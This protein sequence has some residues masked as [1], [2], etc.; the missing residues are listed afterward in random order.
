MDDALGWILDVVESVDPVLRMTIAGVAMLLELSVV[1]GLIVPGDTIVIVA[2]MG[3]TSVWEGV[4]LA[5]AAALGSLVGESIG[6][7]IGRWL[8]PRIRTSW[9]GR[10]IGEKNWDRAERYLS[11]RGGLA[12]FLARFLPVLRQ[13]VPLTVGMSHY[14][15]RR[16]ILW[17]APSC[18]LWAALYVGIAATAAGSYRELAGEAQGAVF[19]LVGGLILLVGVVFLIEKLISRFEKR[20]LD[21]E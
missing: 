13:L 11:R 2:A 6:F 14:S 18:I 1:I 10:R 17:A 8:G 3:V 19:V 7:G 21:E 15:F 20:H 12:I 9:I 4:L 5:A 16:F